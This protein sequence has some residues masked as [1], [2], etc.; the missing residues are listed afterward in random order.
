MIEDLEYKSAKHTKYVSQESLSGYPDRNLASLMELKVFEGFI[1]AFSHFLV[2]L[3]QRNNDIVVFT[4]KSGL[5]RFR[6]W[7]DRLFSV[8][9]F[10][11]LPSDLHLSISHTPVFKRTLWS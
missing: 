4:R 2:V 6:F 1:Y 11:T 8:F 5:D 7:A 10:V 3:Q 9:D